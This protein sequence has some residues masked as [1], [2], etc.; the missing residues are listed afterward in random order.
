MFKLIL[1]NKTIGA[2]ILFLINVWDF[3]LNHIWVCI[4]YEVKA[5]LNALFVKSVMIDDI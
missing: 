3:C 2:Y 4:D 5:H 1:S